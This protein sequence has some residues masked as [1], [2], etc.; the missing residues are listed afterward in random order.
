MS[1]SFVCCGIWRWWR[2]SAR[3]FRGSASVYSSAQLLL[4]LGMDAVARYCHA[5]STRSRVLASRS[6][7]RH[8]DDAL[9]LIVLPQY[10]VMLSPALILTMMMSRRLVLSY[11]PSYSLQIGVVPTCCKFFLTI[12]MLFYGRGLIHFNVINGT[13]LVSIMSSFFFVVS[14]R[15]FK[16]IGVPGYMTKCVHH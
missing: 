15:L 11:L 3:P 9:R 10:G 14:R 8:R 5:G 1:I 7:P 2:G 13:P 12:Y 6:I 16:N 4:V